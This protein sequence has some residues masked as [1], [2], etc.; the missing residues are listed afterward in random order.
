LK[1]GQKGS[2]N[3]AVDKKKNKESFMSLSPPPPLVH[4]AGIRFSKRDLK[5]MSSE[6]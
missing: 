5:G 1:S 4:E 2:H 3:K 6:F